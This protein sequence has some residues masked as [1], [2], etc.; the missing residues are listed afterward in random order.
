MYVLIMTKRYV[1]LADED[2]AEAHRK[3]SP[4]DKMDL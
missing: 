2:L 3:T 4:V 1:V